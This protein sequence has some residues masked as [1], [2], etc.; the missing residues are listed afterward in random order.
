MWKPHL[1]AKVVDPYGNLVYRR[2]VEKRNRL[3]ASDEALARVRQG[4][5]EVVERNNGSGRRAR[6]EGLEIRGKTGSAER[7]SRENRTKDVWFIAYT[8]WRERTLALAV[9]I[10]E[11]DS[12]ATD[13]AP[14]ASQFFRRYLLEEE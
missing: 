6:T 10:Q 13:C 1:V 11:G 7:G 12:G 9:V 4:M 3:A 2:V 8:T 14:L 5:L